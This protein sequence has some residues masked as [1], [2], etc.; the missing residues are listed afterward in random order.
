MS[1]LSYLFHPNPGHLA[2]SSPSAAA[3]L[4][5]C[6]ALIILSFAIKYWRRRLKNS[7]TRKLSRAWSS[8]SFWFGASGLLLVVSRVEQIQFIAMRFL[9]AFWG[10]L[11]LFL[12]FLQWRIFRMRHYEVLPRVDNLDPRDRYLPGKKRIG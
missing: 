1:L 11:L 2:Y 6:T 8:I 5:A 3:V 7:V 12:I 9:W 10:M 4:G